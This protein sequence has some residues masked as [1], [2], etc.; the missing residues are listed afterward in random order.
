LV[1]VPLHGLQAKPD[2]AGFN[3]HFSVAA[4]AKDA[5]GEVAGSKLTRDR[6]VHVTADQLKMGQFRG[7]DGDR[8]STRKIYS[9]TAVMDRESG[10]MGTGHSEFS[11]APT[12]KGVGISR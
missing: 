4:L 5:K 9:E 3:V 6:S 2:A 11:V 8:A 10:N 12:A 7:Q 1:E